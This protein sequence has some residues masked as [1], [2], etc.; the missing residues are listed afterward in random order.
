MAT[1]DW[2]MV[3]WSVSLFLGWPLNVFSYLIGRGVERLREER[4]RDQAEAEALRA[5]GLSPAPP[6]ATVQRDA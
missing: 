4:R 5:E 6:P 3:A 1:P 2:V